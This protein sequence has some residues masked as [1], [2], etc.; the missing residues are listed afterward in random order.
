MPEEIKE[1]AEVAKT[2]DDATPEVAVEGEKVETPETPAEVKE[3]L[4][5]AKEQLTD[6]ALSDKAREKVQARFDALTAKNVALEQRLEVAEKA[7]A[8][9]AKASTE[10]TEEGLIA[11]L[12]D[13]DHPEYHAYAQRELAKLDTQKELDKRDMVAKSKQEEAKSIALAVSKWP[14]LGIPG[15]AIALLGNQIYHQEKLEGVK[16][17]WYIAGQLA[18]S[19]LGIAAINDQT[20]AQLQKKVDKENAKKALASGGKKVVVSDTASYEKLKIKALAEGEKSLAWKQWQKAI[21]EKQRG[22]II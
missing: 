21:V 11:L 14:D 15:S 10:V 12:R 7:L 18:A 1:G 5:D 4:K 19:Q 13:A 8:D 22:K 3:E 17:G 16:N 20:K 6:P 2:L 9:K